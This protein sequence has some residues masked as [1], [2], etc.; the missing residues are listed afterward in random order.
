VTAEAQVTG[1]QP[2]SALQSQ[3]W[4]YITAT[5]TGTACDMTLS[6]TVNSGAPIYTMGNLCL[7]SGS[8]VNA[9]PLEV[10]GGLTVGTGAVG[11]LSTPIDRA[12]IAG[13]CAGHTCSA[14]DKV[15]ASTI[16]ST[17]PNLTPPTIDWDYWYNNAAPGPKHGCDTFSGTPPTFDND[18]LRNKSLTT[19]FSLTPATSYVCR[20]GPAGNPTGELSWDATTR[21]LTVEGTIF[22]DGQAKVDNA[23]LDRYVGLGVL[24]VSGAFQVTNGSKLCAVTSGL[25]CDFSANAW[26]PNQTFFSIVSNGNGGVGVGAGNSIQLGC[27]D[28]FQGGLFGTNTVYFSSG[29]FPAKQQGPIVA[30]TI[31]LSSGSQTYPFKKLDSA[32]SGL[33]GQPAGARTVLPPHNFSA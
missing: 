21:I 32:P 1:S 29:A 7:G 10:K 5:R 25:D 17:P 9:G 3:T 4:N 26:D 2:V 11:S 30:S 27:T 23:Q 15:Y 20:V 14:A 33:P 24:Y 22:I 31:V 8:I 28:R 6:A 13:G 18:A 19:V 16:T 12:D